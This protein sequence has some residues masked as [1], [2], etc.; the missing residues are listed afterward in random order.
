VPFPYQI[1][2]GRIN[3]IALYFCPSIEAKKMKKGAKWEH[4]AKMLTFAY[5]A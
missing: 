5:S 4:R 3:G 1:A 2:E